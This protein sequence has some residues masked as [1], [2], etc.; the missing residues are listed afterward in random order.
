MFNQVLEKAMSMIRGDSDNDTPTPNRTLQKRVYRV[1]T[2]LRGPD[3]REAH[4]DAT[5]AF[6]TKYTTPLRCWAF[7]TSASSLAAT[8]PVS[9]GD[10]APESFS[11]WQEMSQEVSNML[12]EM[13]DDQYRGPDERKYPEK[14]HDIHRHFLTHIRDGIEALS[15]L[16]TWYVED[17]NNFSEVEKIDEIDSE[18]Q[19][20]E[21]TVQELKNKRQDLV[22]SDWRGLCQGDLF[23]L[24][25]A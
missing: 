7:D 24:L 2:A 1:I 21:E 16:T 8:Y 9:S 20:A 19:N 25:T 15:D 13:S 3:Q 14:S 23:A 11:G 18:I 10:D 12:S 5:L 6:K 22:D 17:V 4:E